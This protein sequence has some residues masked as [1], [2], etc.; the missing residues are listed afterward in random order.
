MSIAFCPTLKC[1]FSTTHIFGLFCLLPW[2]SRQFFLFYVSFF[3]CLSSCRIAESHVCGTSSLL[4]TFLFCLNQLSFYCFAFTSSF[5]FPFASKNN[6]LF[7]YPVCS[8]PSSAILSCNVCLSLLLLYLSTC[9]FCY[10]F[11]LASSTFLPS[12]PVS[13]FHLPLQL[14]CMSIVSS[15]FFCHPVCSTLHLKL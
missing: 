5:S 6:Y 14:S 11:C 7:S 2:M 4:F 10:P 12:P 15:A 3:R 13:F 1:C 9:L 8:P